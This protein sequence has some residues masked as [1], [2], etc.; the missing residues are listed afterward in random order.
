[1]PEL[2][3]GMTYALMITVLVLRPGGLFGRPE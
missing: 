3:L 1:V 2:A